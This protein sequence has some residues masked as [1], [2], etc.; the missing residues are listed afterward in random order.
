MFQPRV[1]L[2]GLEFQ[3]VGTIK[4]VTVTAQPSIATNRHSKVP[5]LLYQTTKSLVMVKSSISPIIHFGS[6]LI[7]ALSI[8]LYLIYGTVASLR[9][10]F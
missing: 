1:D 4:C 6:S 3:V 9:T 7:D 8:E 5:S 10:T 2:V